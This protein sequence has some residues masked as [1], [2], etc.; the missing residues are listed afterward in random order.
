LGAGFSNT[1]K[2]ETKSKGD[3]LDFGGADG[4]GLRL[5]SGIWAGFG[6]FDPAAWIGGLGSTFLLMT[7]SG[8]VMFSA[9]LT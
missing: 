6:E 3:L 5:D 2:G 7:G 4:A 1:S 8:D 9:G